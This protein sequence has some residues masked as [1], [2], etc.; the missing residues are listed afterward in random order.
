[1]A[2]Q[3]PGVG[4]RGAV[5]AP[6]RRARPDPSPPLQRQQLAVAPASCTRH[7]T[8]SNSA[9]LSRSGSSCPSFCACQIGRPCGAHHPVM[10]SWAA[11]MQHAMLPC[12]ARRGCCRHPQ[13]LAR[14]FY[15]NRTQFR[16]TQWRSYI[17][18]C[19]CRCTLPPPS[20]PQKRKRKITTWVKFSLLLHLKFSHLLEKCAPSNL[21]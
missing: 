9:S 21:F 18:A 15:N 11:A 14:D 13:E 17:V 19:G 1:M 2:V 5:A 4:T 12:H 20:L 6:S 16:Y 10:Q 7:D 8:R 3:Q